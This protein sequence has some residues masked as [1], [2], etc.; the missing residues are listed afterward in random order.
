MKSILSPTISLPWDS[1]D[2]VLLDMDGTLLDLHFDNF[3]WAEHIPAC[4]AKRHCLSLSESKQKLLTFSNSVKGQL[5]WYCLDYWSEKL[6]LDVAALKKDVDHKI[7][8]RP[9]V[10]EFLNFLKNKNKRI[11]LATNA[12]PKTLELKL[13]RTDFA[14][15]FNEL[16]SSHE[17]GYPKEENAYWEILTQRYE[18]DAGRSLFIDDSLS[19]LRAASQFGIRYILGISKPDLQKE[20]MDC[21]PYTGIRDFSQLF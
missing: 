10:I 18:I 13:M 16:S 1:I 20:E 3:F 8:F 11:I 17:L 6:S 7:S 5:E 15:Y 2:T 21:S 4:Y 9:N 19:V 14:G 12:H